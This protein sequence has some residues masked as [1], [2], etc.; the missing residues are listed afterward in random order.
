MK[1]N[2]F[3]LCHL[4]SLSF[5]DK[6]ITNII[7]IGIY[8]FYLRN[9]GRS[10]ITPLLL[11]YF[12]KIK[13]FRLYLFTRKVNSEKESEY[14]IYHDIFRINIKKCT[15]KNIIK[16]IRKK[17][18]DIFIFQNS[19]STEIKSL[20]NI[21]N[22]KTIFYQHQSLFFWIYKNYTHFKSIYEEY[23][24]SKYIVSLIHLEN[25]YIFRKWGIESIFMNNFITYDLKR[26][27]PSDLSDKNIFMIGRAEQRLKRFKLGIYAMEYIIQQIPECELKILSEYKKMGRLFK[28]IDA[29]NLKYS[30]KFYGYTSTPEIF[31]KK[32]VC[33]HSHLLV[34]LLALYYVK[35]KFMVYLI[36]F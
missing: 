19:N 5:N 31:L 36:L 8:S 16:E 7:K 26:V 32:L 12:Y 18:L 23:H 1:E 3:G 24:S 6:K 27:I 22:I 11:N 13:I 35:Q 2:Y 33:I 14:Y 9:G 21:N 20:N 30:I 17:K 4:L 29:L 10:R 28:I 15:I 25:D 34:N